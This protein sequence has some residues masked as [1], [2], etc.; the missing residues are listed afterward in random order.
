MDEPTLDSVRQAQRDAC[1]R[2]QQSDKGREAYKRANA[3][4]R[5]TEAGKAVMR[6]SK[7]R[8]RQQIRERKLLEEALHAD[9][10][11]GRVTVELQGED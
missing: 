8:W 7:R 2:Y 3:K 4:Y 9:A 5:H 11:E 1:R 10:C 6:E